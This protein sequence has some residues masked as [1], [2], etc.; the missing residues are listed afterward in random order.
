MRSKEGIEFKIL[1]EHEFKCSICSSLAGKVSL[2]M[3][4]NSSTMFIAS[5]T[6]SVQSHV[7]QSVLSIAQTALSEGDV[8]TLY[9]IDIEFTPFYCPRC[10]KCYCEQH[11]RYWDVHD[12]DGWY[13]STR[14][15]CPVGHE[16]MLSD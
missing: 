12:E 4:D 13:D 3:K 8:Q 6:G 7:P 2:K 10:Q 14:G 5:F 9:T 1:A 16:R 11:W 15:E